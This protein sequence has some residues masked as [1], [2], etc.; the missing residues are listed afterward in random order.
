[1]KTYS[2]EHFGG[3]PNII[4]EEGGKREPHGIIFT[5]GNPEAALDADVICRALNR[6]AI[7]RDAVHNNATINAQVN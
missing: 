5:H 6:A 3:S 7:E 4:V 1:M 2:V